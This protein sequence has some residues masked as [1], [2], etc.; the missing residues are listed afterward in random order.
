MCMQLPPLPPRITLP[1]QFV[2]CLVV[3]QGKPAH[4]CVFLP[5]IRRFPSAG[6]RHLC[7]VLSVAWLFV[8]FLSPPVPA[9][10]DFGASHLPVNF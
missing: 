1:L 3:F 2:L 9:P 4:F 10:C 7:L 5:S 6:M 8:C